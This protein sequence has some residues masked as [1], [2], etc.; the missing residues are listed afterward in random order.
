LHCATGGV[1]PGSSS[2]SD[3]DVNVHAIVGAHPVRCTLRQRSSVNLTSSTCGPPPRKQPAVKFSS[4]QDTHQLKAVPAPPTP[5][6]RSKEKQASSEHASIHPSI[7]KASHKAKATTKERKKSVEAAAPV[8]GGSAK[9]P[10]GR[11][12]KPAYTHTSMHMQYASPPQQQP[13][14]RSRVVRIRMA[15]SLLGPSPP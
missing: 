15:T 6:E 10:T 8:D 11:E 4:A 13:P 1:R 7:L 5:N 9:P 12:T 2:S 14:R 3:N